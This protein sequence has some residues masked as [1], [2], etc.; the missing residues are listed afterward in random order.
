MVLLGVGV[1]LD[2]IFFSQAHKQPRGCGRGQTRLKCPV[3]KHRVRSPGCYLGPAPVPLQPPPAGEG[4]IPHTRLPSHVPQ[5]AL[6][7]NPTLYTSQF[8][9][10]MPQGPGIWC[11]LN[12]IPL[13]LLLLR[14][15]PMHAGT[16]SPLTPSSSTLAMKPTLVL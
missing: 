4:I 16:C 12:V 15:L 5:G 7:S 6:N 11:L 10:A 2:S 8:Y 9:I 13:I 3:S 14:P 1:G